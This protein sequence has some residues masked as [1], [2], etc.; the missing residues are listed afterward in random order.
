ML[1]DETILPPGCLNRVQE[2][3]AVERAVAGVLE[4]GQRDDIYASLS[5][6]IKRR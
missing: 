3:E 4:A 1:A 5:P 6:V 2:F